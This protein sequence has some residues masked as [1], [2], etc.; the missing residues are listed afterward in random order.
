MTIGYGDGTFRPSRNVSRFE[1][2]L[3]MER[4]ARIAGANPVDVVQDF[5]A[6]GLRP[7]EPDRH[8]AA[9][10]SAARLG[11]RQRLPRE[12]GTETRRH[13]HRRRDRGRR[14]VHRLAPES[15]QNVETN[16]DGTFTIKTVAAK[17][18]DY[19]A[20]SRRLQNRVHDSAA[21]A[22]YELG[23]AS[24]TGMGYFSPGDSVN[25]G[26][27]AAFVTRALAHTTARPEGLTIQSDGP[28]EVI[29]SVR[30]ANFH[31]MANAAVDVFSASA[32]KVGEAFKEDGTCDTPRVSDVGGNAKECE[33]DAL[34]AVTGLSGDYDPSTITVNVKAGGTT[35]WAWTGD[36]GDKG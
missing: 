17:D 1:M 7:R 35:V 9:D 30:D 19:F 4:S 16:D 6:D 20:D 24:G 33:I 28:G 18:W 36:L 10:R 5:A 21:S 27:M 13:L 26:E 23:V 34:D 8:G 11:D 15:T 25:R 12:R 32:D 14:R 2:V 31:P 29:I 22:L 3:F